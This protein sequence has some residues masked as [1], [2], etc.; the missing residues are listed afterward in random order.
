MIKLS[1][2]DIGIIVSYVIIVLIFGFLIRR[3]A[4]SDTNSYFLGG[5]KIPW[6]VLGASGMSSNFDITGTMLIVS[7]F[8]CPRH[9]AVLGNR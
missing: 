3:R 6:W 2:L 7:L 9:K 8:L 1:T 4:S 5:K